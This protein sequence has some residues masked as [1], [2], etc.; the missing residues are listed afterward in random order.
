LGRD[1]RD[2]VNEVLSAA[3]TFE[4]QESGGLQRFLHWFA[5]GEVEVKRD[6]EARLNAVRVMTVHG[7]KGLKRRSSSSL[8]PPPTRPSSARPVR[9]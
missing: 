3:L 7:A 2:P 5:S 8:T 4:G 1:K 6:P 9:P